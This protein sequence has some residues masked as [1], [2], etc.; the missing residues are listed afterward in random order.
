MLVYRGQVPADLALDLPTLAGS[1]A[2]PIKYGYALVGEVTACGAA[3]TSHQ[4]GDNVFGV[5]PPSDA[6]TGTGCASQ[7]HPGRDCTDDGGIGSQSGNRPSISSTIC[8]LPSVM[9]WWW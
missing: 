2:F 3:V 6:P 8:A 5:A 7:T 1:F 9:W 4:V